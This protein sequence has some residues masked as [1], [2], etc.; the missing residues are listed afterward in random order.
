MCCV[1]WVQR[2]VARDN[3][4]RDSGFRFNLRVVTGKDDAEV[5]LLASP[6][7]PHRVLTFLTLPHKRVKT[8]VDSNP[9]RYIKRNRP[10]IRFR[11]R[12]RHE[13]ESPA[14]EI[15][16]RGRHHRFAKPA[17]RYSGARTPA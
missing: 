14:P 6:Y 17:E 1:H 2:V 8:L 15:P 10:V 4:H 9:M 11:H 3:F 16:G 7:A 13:P 5:F 12:Q